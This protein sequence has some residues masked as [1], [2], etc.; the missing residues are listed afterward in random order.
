MKDKPILKTVRLIKCDSITNE[1]INA[2]FK[3]GI[4][5]EAK[6][7]NLIK[8]I[9]SD[10]QAGTVNFEDLKYGIYYIKEIQAPEGYLL[11]D[12]IVKIEINKNGIFV[13]GEL[14]KEDNSICE[15]IYYNTQIPKI[16]TGN[17]R[18]YPLLLSSLLIS[19][20]GL[21][22]LISKNKFLVS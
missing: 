6:C 8:E 10:K 22:F 11:S 18:N 13:D 19:L 3:F 21:I 16:Q 20:S 5:E 15:F 1:I 12:K 4:Y 9:E 2:N 17:E 14:L 7:I